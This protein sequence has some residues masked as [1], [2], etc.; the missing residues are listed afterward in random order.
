MAEPTVAVYT[1]AA[2][3][4]LQAAEHHSTQPS[5]VCGIAIRYWRYHSHLPFTWTSK[6]Y[7]TLIKARY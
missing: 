6:K 5:D 4:Q 2:M 7:A 3:M 1:A